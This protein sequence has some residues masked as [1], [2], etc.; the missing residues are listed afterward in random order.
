MMSELPLFTTPP[1]QRITELRRRLHHHNQKYYAEDA[2][3]ISDASYDAL[4][5][6]LQDLEAA[7]PALATADSP[8]QTVGTQGIV[9]DF[10]KVRHGIPM[11]SLGNAFSDEDIADFL[12]KIRRFLNLTDEQNIDIVTEP[13]I[14]GLSANIRYE[15]GVFVQAATRGDGTEG[16]DITANLRTIKTI[17][18][19]L[20]GENIPDLLEVRGEVFLSHADFAALNQQQ[21]AQ[22]KLRPSELKN[23][24]Y[25]LNPCSISIFLCHSLLSFLAIFGSMFS[26]PYCISK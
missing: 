25:S 16:E 3:E 17:P 1:A 8:T 11:L 21:T 7:Y 6:E 26:I 20:Q 14:D 2:P 13:K 15:K 9:T 12:Q 5:R 18:L 23:T 22:N 24:N 4:L 19:R 10:G